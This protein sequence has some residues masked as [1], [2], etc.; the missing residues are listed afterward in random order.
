[1]RICDFGMSE[2]KDR[3]KTMSV[4]SAGGGNGRAVLL[5]PRLTLHAFNA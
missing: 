2:A 4:A 5:D 3:S 1:M